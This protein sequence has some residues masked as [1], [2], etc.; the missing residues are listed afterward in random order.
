MDPSTV[1]FENFF[2]LLENSFSCIIIANRSEWYWRE[3]DFNIS[4]FFL[5]SNKERREADIGT[6]WGPFK[7][8]K[9]IQIYPSIEKVSVPKLNTHESQR[10]LNERCETKMRTKEKYLFEGMSRPNMAAI[11]LIRRD[12][13]NEALV[14]GLN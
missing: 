4:L 12:R 10:N 7:K 8:G 11:E 2:P 9:S 3:R 13:V 14:S 6:R 1:S 5:E